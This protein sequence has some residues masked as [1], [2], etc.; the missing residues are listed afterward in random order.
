MFSLPEVP[1]GFGNG[2]EGSEE[3]GHRRV[4]RLNVRTAPEGVRAANPVI[5]LSG[6]FRS[7]RCVGMACMVGNYEWW[8]QVV[9]LLEGAKL[10][11][12]ARAERRSGREHGAIRRTRLLCLKREVFSMRYI[13]CDTSS[14]GDLLVSLLVHA[15]ELS[16]CRMVETVAPRLF[17]AE[18]CSVE[19]R[20]LGTPGWCNWLA[21]VDAP[22][23][24][25]IRAGVV[26]VSCGAVVAI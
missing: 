7:V 26:D 20:F 9:R 22:L 21:S 1:P 13:P 15:T 12:P 11:P 17:W 23:V 4:F 19:V 16:T 3:S 6:V 5:W 2:Q 18:V 10:R 14:L 25:C 24:S 8:L